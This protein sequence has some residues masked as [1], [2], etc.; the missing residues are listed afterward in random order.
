MKV[1]QLPYVTLFL[2]TTYYSA[3]TSM[4]SWQLPTISTLRMCWDHALLGRPQPMIKH[5]EG[6]WVFGTGHFY[7]T[8]N[9]S[10]KQSLLQSSPQSWVRD[11]QIC[12]V[13]LGLPPHPSSCFISHLSFTV[14][15]PQQLSVSLTI[16]EHLAPGRLKWH[17]CLQIHVFISVNLQQINTLLK[18]FSFIDS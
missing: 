9:S 12:I 15:T 13:V 17:T 11:Y 18:L 3:A 16:S 5:S 7:P 2:S 4:V 14:V 1:C 6:R 10:N 8:R